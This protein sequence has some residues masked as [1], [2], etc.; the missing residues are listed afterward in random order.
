[1][2]GSGP[3][4]AALA[5]RLRPRYRV[6]VFESRRFSSKQTVTAP[7][8]NLSKEAPPAIGES[9]P[10]CAKTL[11]L[12]FGLLERFL[13]DGHAERTAMVASWDSPESVWFDPLRDPNGPGWLLDRK[14]FD[15]SLR[16][17]ALAAGAVLTEGC[18]RLE[19]NRCDGQWI[20]SAQGHVHRAPVLIDAS[21]RGSCISRRLGRCAARRDALYCSSTCRL[22]STTGTAPPAS[23]DHSMAACV[24]PA[25][26]GSWPSDGDDPELMHCQAPT[27]WPRPA[28]TTASSAA[29]Q[30]NGAGDQ[31]DP[32]SAWPSCGQCG[33]GLRG[34]ACHRGFY[35][36]GD[37]A[38]P[39]DPLPL[40]G[41]SMPWRQLRLSLPPSS[42]VTHHPRPRTSLNSKRSQPPSHSTARHYTGPQR[43]SSD[44]SGPTVGSAGPISPCPVV[45]RMRMTML[46]RDRSGL[47][48]AARLRGQLIRPA[49]WNWSVLT[50]DAAIRLHCRQRSGSVLMRY[51][52]RL[53][54]SA[55]GATHHVNHHTAAWGS[56]SS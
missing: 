36:V 50:G 40:R 46:G 34:P 54:R 41:R 52:G 42:D 4:G 44:R 37:A 39:F 22:M 35:A 6:L 13:A 3:A 56:G 25:A 8:G 49:G 10:G 33:A 32:A 31:P 53:G 20:V 55:C 14:R 26:S 2:V 15:A 17:A 47:G 11:L 16:A 9:L 1:M 43:F 23:A 18:G 24:R 38:I 27:R 30:Q 48:Y 12:R 45:A 51:E 5:C 29:D 7:S 28:T 21:G 19:F